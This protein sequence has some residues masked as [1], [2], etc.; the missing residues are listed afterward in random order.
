[1]DGG[2]WWVTVHGVAKSQIQ[3]RDFTFTFF[4]RYLGF[5]GDTSGKEPAC[6]RRVLRRRGFNPW[7]GKIPWGRAQQPATVFLPG[8]SQ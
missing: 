3:Q 7:V 2:A 8:E 4:H 5:P 6:Q 1:M